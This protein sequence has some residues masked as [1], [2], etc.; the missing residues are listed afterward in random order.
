MSKVKRPAIYLTEVEFERLS[1]L[2]A[3]AEGREPAA[4]TLIEEL[5]RARITSAKS[6]PADI[7]RM[8]DR[9][10]FTYDGIHYENFALVYPYE[11]NIEARRISVLTQVGAMLIGL[12]A[13]GSIEWLGNDGRQHKIDV[14]AVV[15]GE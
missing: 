5:G 15:R 2:A 7:V 4:D 13:G 8:H 1:D 12:K 10:N 3:A 11:A 9:V 14:I 6:I